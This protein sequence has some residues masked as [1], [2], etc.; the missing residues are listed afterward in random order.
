[1]RCIKS[2]ENPKNIFDILYRAEEITSFKLSVLRLEEADFVIRPEVRHLSWADFDKAEEI[3][4]A[5]ES[6][7]R[8]CLNDIKMVF[9]TPSKPMAI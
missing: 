1:M 7:A 9:D 2:T 6:A 3:I 5:G 8:N 4:R